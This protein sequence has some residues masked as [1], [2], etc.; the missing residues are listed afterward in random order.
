MA[1]VGAWLALTL[2]IASVATAMP[3]L[4]VVCGEVETTVCEDTI[5]AARTRGLTR[6][7]PLILSASVSAGPA[8]PA[9]IGHRATVTFELAGT[10]G[11][12]TVKLFY[13]IG[14][15]WG[16]VV[17]SGDG[18]AGRVVVHPGGTGAPPWP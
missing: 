18:R 4:R 2:I 17:D 8:W 16:G 11:S 7:H 5:A 14:G 10:P 1:V 13:D 6:P 15:H 12:T 3:P 9:A